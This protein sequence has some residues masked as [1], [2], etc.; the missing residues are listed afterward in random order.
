MMRRF[1]CWVWLRLV[2]LPGLASAQGTKLW[3]VDR[4]E[5]F[6]KGTAEG[7]AIRSD[8]AL[9]AGPATSLL[10]ATGGSYV[11]SVAADAAGNAY[12]GMGGSVAG[13]AAVM[14]VGADGKATKIF[15]GKELGVQAVRV[16]ADG[17]LLI[18]TSPDGKVYWVPGS[19]AVAGGS[20][21]AVL[22]D[23]TQTDEKPKYIWDVA[24]IG[25]SAF[26]ATGAPAAVYRVELAGAGKGQ[27]TKPVL[28]FKTADQHIRSL[29]AG[30]DGRLWAGSDGAGVIYRIDTTT[31]IETT[32]AGAKPF[33]VYAAARKE[34]TSL[35]MDA[36][37]N[38]Y[39]AGVGTKGAGA[40][41]PLPVTGNVGVT[42]TFSQPGSANAAGANTLVPDGSEIYGLG[43]MGLRASC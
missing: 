34:I 24:V 28:L 7:V 29:L 25:G 39:A 27:T 10:Y 43:R 31:R 33:A 30:A 20:G 41:P 36:A 38:V 13:S 23:R 15:E 8:G 9:E 16:S 40:L 18:A 11:W 42:I 26:V 35:A 17:A 21:A 12:V 19:A 3:S 14:K 37:G 1:L 4:Y 2:A 32:G 6:S 5:D 22:F